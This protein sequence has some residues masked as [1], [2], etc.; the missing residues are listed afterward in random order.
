VAMRDA[1]CP[2]GPRV[3]ADGMTVRG[4]IAIDGRFMLTASWRAPRR[5]KYV[6]PVT[7]RRPDADVGAIDKYGALGHKP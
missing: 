5:R 7:R 6:V 2:N 4:V 1:N 3:R